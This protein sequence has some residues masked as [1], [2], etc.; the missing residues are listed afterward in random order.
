MEI[1]GRLFRRI[2]PLLVLGMGVC[3]LRDRRRR[4]RARMRRMEQRQEEM[5]QLLREIRDAVKAKV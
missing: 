2:C 1:A 4:W 3:Y 5:A